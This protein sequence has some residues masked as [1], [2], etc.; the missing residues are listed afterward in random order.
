MRRRI[1]YYYAAAISLISIWR[2]IIRPLPPRMQ[3]RRHFFSRYFMSTSFLRCFIFRIMPLLP[4]PEVEWYHF[5]AMP[6]WCFHDVSAIATNYAF[7]GRFHRA[8]DARA[9]PPWLLR[10]PCA[11]A[12]YRAHSH[13]QPRG[14]AWISRMNTRFTPDAGGFIGQFFRK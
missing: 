4:L 8:M 11:G 10:P 1:W 3:V 13:F 14:R 9:M 6:C 2:Y 12:A 5:A 7:T